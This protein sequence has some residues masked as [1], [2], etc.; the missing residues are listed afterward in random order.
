MKRR[1]QPW[2]TWR[3]WPL[4]LA[5]LPNFP[6][7]CLS[8]WYFG[9]FPKLPVQAMGICRDSAEA[10]VGSFSTVTA[11]RRRKRVSDGVSQDESS[12]VVLDYRAVFESAPDGIVVV[13]D[14]GRIVEI[15]PCVL[16]QFGYTAEELIGEPVEILVPETA[17]AAHERHRASFQAEPVSRPMGAGLVLV[18]RR[19]DGS[20]FPVEI[21]LSPWK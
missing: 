2:S 12:S 20:G 6:A 10:P 1:T 18:G 5:D 9:R 16:K 14:D 7:R 3:R 17:R 11:S 13:N 8:L 4:S 21:S 19:K 15:N